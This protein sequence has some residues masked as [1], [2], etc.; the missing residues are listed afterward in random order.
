MKPKTVKMLGLVPLLLVG[1]EAVAGEQPLRATGLEEIVVMAR[2]RPESLQDVPVAV[3]VLNSKAFER[4]GIDDISDLSTG[5]IPTL[6]VTPFPLNPASSVIFIRGIGNTDSAQATKDSGVGVYIDGVYLGRIQGLGSEIADLEHVEIL[7][8]PQGI[9]FGKNSTGG[10]LNMVSKK[11]TGEG[12]FYQKLSTGNYDA[13]RS[14]TRLEMPAVGPLSSKFSY[15]LS[16]KEGYVENVN[17]NQNDFGE[18]SKKG[19]RATFLLDFLDGAGVEMIYT[20]DGADIETTNLYYQHHFIESDPVSGEPVLQGNNIL[21]IDLEPDRRSHSRGDTDPLEPNK[22]KSTG[23]TLSVTWDVTDDISLKSITSQ[24]ELTD[25]A[26]ANFGSTNGF[27]LG[28]GIWLSGTFAT[29]DTEQTQTSQEFQLTGLTSDESVNYLLG[30]Y[31]FKED[32]D[33]SDNVGFTLL[34][35]P[36]ATF[37]EP[38]L[39]PNNAVKVESE[40]LALYGQAIWT[41][42]IL[43]DQ[44]QITL[45]GR[46]NT[47]KKQGVRFRDQ[48]VPSNDILNVDDSHFD[49]AITFD[50][51]W[52]DYFNTYLKWS[53][54]YRAGGANTRSVEFLN[55]DREIVK[56]VEFGFKSHFWD[57]RARVNLAIHQSDYEDKQIDFS[58]PDFII[59]SETINSEESVEISG[60]ELDATVVPTEGF[61]LAFQYA[62]LDIDV[63]VQRNI[64]SGDMERFVAPNAPKHAASLSAQYEFS[65]TAIGN[66]SLHVLYTFTDEYFYAPTHTEYTDQYGLWSGRIILANGPLTVALWGKNLADEEYVAH[67]IYSNG[68][69]I[70]NAYGAPRTY[71]LDLTYNYE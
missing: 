43:D 61:T 54:A 41:P 25:K 71:G 13:F 27:D 55:Y 35:S 64:L 14:V 17:A 57:D 65:A 63:P 51:T 46:Y 44:L 68:F 10:A 38:L 58:N 36:G 6:R 22:T 52:N 33:E 67:S 7:R 62:Y 23:H 29:T 30:F 24:R 69:G 37:I 31:A 19:Y 28:N 12:G 3:S 26:F 49:P 56:T 50:Y 66:P 1:N 60:L 21:S 5:V 11:P 2:K 15:L 39:Q 47:D 42:P 16:K 45:G 4:M 9:I 53:S 70:A 40:S 59:L 32:I 18:E 48:G 8:G 20:I 34:F